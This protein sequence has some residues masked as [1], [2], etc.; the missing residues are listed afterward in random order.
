M[1][2]NEAQAYEAQVMEEARR[3][4]QEEQELLEQMNQVRMEEQQKLIETNQMQESSTLQGAINAALLT[5][6]LQVSSPASVFIISPDRSIK[7]T[8]MQKSV[9]IAE[10]KYRK[11]IRR[12]NSGQEIEP[13][14]DVQSLYTVHPED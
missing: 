14:L 3:I 12:S 1:L 5:S 9:V 10:R 7:D 4:Q 6:Q 2:S 11:G 13:E 8:Q